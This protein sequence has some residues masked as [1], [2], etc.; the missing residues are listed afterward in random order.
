MLNAIVTMMT[1]N[2]KFDDLSSLYWRTPWL[3]AHLHD[4]KNACV[5]I[6]SLPKYKLPYFP[7]YKGP[8]FAQMPQK[9]GASYTWEALILLILFTEFL[10]KNWRGVLHTMVSYTRENTAMVKMERKLWHL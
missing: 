9:V 10:P 8:P 1:C 7:V 2:R 3:K 4:C 5:F 6:L